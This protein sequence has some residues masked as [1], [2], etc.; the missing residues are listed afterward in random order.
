MF[1]KW[2]TKFDSFIKCVGEM[3]LLLRK[4][5]W[6]FDSH[7]CNKFFCPPNLRD[8]PRL[9]FSLLIKRH[10]VISVRVLGGWGIK[11]TN[12]LLLFNLHMS[13]HR[14]YISK[15]QPTKMQRFLDLFLS[16][17]CSICFMWFLCPSSGAQ[18][19]TYS[20]RHCQNNTAACCYRG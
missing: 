2:D 6:Q 16:I 5:E 13:V 4:K 17:N 7:R 18:N 20:V 10:W 9:P 14:K 11:L 12:Y 1:L 3:L 15:V 19:C 8:R